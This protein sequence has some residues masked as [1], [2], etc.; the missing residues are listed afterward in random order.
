MDLEFY[1]AEHD[2]AKKVKVLVGGQQDGNHFRRHIVRF[3][4]LFL[5]GKTLVRRWGKVGENYFLP[6]RHHAGEQRHS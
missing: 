5:H 2:H 3:Q 1:V 6:K 4:I